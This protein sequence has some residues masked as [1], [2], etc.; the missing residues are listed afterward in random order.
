VS[1]EAAMLNFSSLPH[2]APMVFAILITFAV[3]FL[4][5]RLVKARQSVA[6]AFAFTPM[7]LFWTLASIA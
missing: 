3:F 5:A 6:L 4:I 1:D 7:L 2:N